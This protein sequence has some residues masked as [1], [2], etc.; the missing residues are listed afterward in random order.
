LQIPGSPGGTIEPF[1]LPGGA[2]V[3]TGCLVVQ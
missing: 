1:K 2:A 3:L